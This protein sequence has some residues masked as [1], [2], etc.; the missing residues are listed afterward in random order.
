MAR[1]VRCKSREP[2]SPDDPV[3]QV[4]LL[5][6]DE[7]GHDEDD[8]CSGRGMQHRRKIRV[9]NATGSTAID[10]LPREWAVVLVARLAHPRATEVEEPSGLLDQ[11]SRENGSRPRQYVRA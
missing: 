11:A 10:E 4:I 3:S 7:D 2:N 8:R 1:V 9:A 6:E 5:H